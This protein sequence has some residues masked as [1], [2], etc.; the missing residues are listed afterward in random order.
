MNGDQADWAQMMRHFIRL[1]L[2]KR[3]I[4]RETKFW[5]AEE[6]LLLLPKLAIPESET[7]NHI[8]QSWMQC[9]K[10]L[11]LDEHNLVLSG[12]I[13]LRQLL[14]LLNRYRARRCFND[15]L[16]YPLLKQLGVNVLSN[17]ADGAGKWI[18]IA[19]E[20]RARGTRLNHTQREALEVFQ[21]W[22]QN[23][24][25]GDQRLENSPSWRWRDSKERWRGWLRQMRFWHKLLSANE[26][27]EDLTVKWPINNARLTWKE[28]W[29]QLWAKGTS[30][31]IT[32][33]FWKIVC[34]A[35]F[36]G[37]RAEKMKVAAEPCCRCKETSEMVSH[38]FYECKPPQEGWQW[39]REN[40]RMTHPH[41]YNARGLLALADEAICDK[42]DG[43]A[44][45]YIFYSLTNTLW[46]DRNSTLFKNS[47]RDTPL[48]VTLEHARLELEGSL[49]ETASDSHWQ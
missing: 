45:A 43:N 49:N 10:Q 27:P 23:V 44:F 47:Q 48:L 41:F 33:W 42:K 20:L 3:S 5:S 35:F 9:R 31:R 13:T 2:Q 1:Q 16:V 40:L 4:G 15:R 12:S 24:H 39:L 32:L 19:S 7:M 25:I 11:T 22:L 6:G 8:V 37:E 14:E 26:T 34:R 46:K 30:P 21:N 29:W 38:L 17:L 18:N 28:R 36:T